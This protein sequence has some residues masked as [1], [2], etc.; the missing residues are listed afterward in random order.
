MADLGKKRRWPFA[1]A[2]RRLCSTSGQGRCL[3]LNPPPALRNL[4]FFICKA[5]VGVLYI[6]H[7][8]QMGEGV[9][10]QCSACSG[11]SAPGTHHVRVTYFYY[12]DFDCFDSFLFSLHFHGPIQGAAPSH[13][14]NPPLAAISPL[15]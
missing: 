12:L 3:G 1:A 14:E 4:P 6:P 9:G 8:M 2:P 7:V 11:V 15:C 10:A 13:H 5:T